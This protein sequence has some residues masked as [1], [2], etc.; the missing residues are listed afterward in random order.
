MWDFKQRCGSRCMQCGCSQCEGGLT[1]L[2]LLLSSLGYAVPRERPCLMTT[3]STWHWSMFT[4]TVELLSVL[5]RKTTVYRAISNSGLV[6]MKALPTGFTKLCQLNCRFR[7]WSSWSGCRW[8]QRGVVGVEGKL[9][10]SF[11]TSWTHQVVVPG[12]VPFVVQVVV[13]LLQVELNPV[14]KANYFCSGLGFT[15]KDVFESTGVQAVTQTKVMSL[16]S[17]SKI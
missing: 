4:S 6:P 14:V 2:L 1:C 16:I 9:L 13:L 10:F 8:R 5:M 11:F 17:Q 15:N 7:T 12:F 3:S